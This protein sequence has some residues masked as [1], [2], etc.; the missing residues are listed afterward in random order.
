MQAQGEYAT[1]PTTAQKGQK[2]KPQLSWFEVSMLTTLLKISSISLFDA[3]PAK[4][5]K[6][7]G[8]TFVFFG[9]FI[10]LL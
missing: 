1:N 10:D 8:W 7:Q 6:L 9:Q 3:K 2:V 4:T 5:P